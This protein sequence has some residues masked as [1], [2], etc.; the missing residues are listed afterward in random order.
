[1]ARI[2]SLILLCLTAACLQYAQSRSTANRPANYWLQTPTEYPLSEDAVSPIVREDRDAYFDKTIGSKSPLTAQTG[3]FSALSEG[4][5]LGEE[6]EIPDVNA[7][8]ILIGDFQGFQSVLSASHR[9]I[10][11]EVTF[12]VDRVLEDTAGR[13]TPGGT[14]TVI[15][16]GGTVDL[17]G[18]ALSYLTTDKEYFIQPAQKYLLVLSYHPQGDFYIIAK[19]W[20]IANGVL[21]PNSNLE[22]I[23]AAQGKS[24]LTGLSEAQAVVSLSN[25][26]NGH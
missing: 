8:S 2:L 23:R 21:R 10:Y 19:T 20:I 16:P 11:T 22:R 26:I 12:K 15:V 1:M 17:N 6:K 4:S 18:R 3:A 13:A 14:A 5:H 7:R 24:V 9:S 25:L